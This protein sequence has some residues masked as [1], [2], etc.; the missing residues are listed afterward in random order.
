M[1][2]SCNTC[3]CEGIELLG[4][5]GNKLVKQYLDLLSY[6][7]HHGNR[8][9]QRAQLADGRRPEVYSIFGYQ[10]R[11]DLNSGFPLLTTKKMPFSAMVH[12]LL[13]FLSGSTNVEYLRKNKVTIWNEWADPNGELGP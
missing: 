5:G 9:A 4:I 1:Y 13:W 7:R 3:Y 11:H 6:V 12:E 10:F 2:T 8:K